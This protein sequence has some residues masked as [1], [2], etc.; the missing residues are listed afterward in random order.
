MLSRKD[1]TCYKS[2]T[3]SNT[4]IARH[5]LHLTS[6]QVRAREMDR[7]NQYAQNTHTG[8]KRQTNSLR[9]FTRSK[10]LLQYAHTPSYLN[11]TLSHKC[12][13]FCSVSTVPPVRTCSCLGCARV[14]ACIRDQSTVLNVSVATIQHQKVKRSPPRSRI[15]TSQ[16]RT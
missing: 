8:K 16:S 14:C 12:W 3:E 5:I 9:V 1:K 11:N 10:E 2:G 7:R 6:C 13:V 4:V 15:P